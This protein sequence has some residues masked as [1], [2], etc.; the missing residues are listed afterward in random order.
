MFCS[1]WFALTSAPSRFTKTIYLVIAG[2]TVLTSR[3]L[4]IW[5]Y[6]TSPTDT[7]NV[8]FEVRS[9]GVLQTL[10]AGPSTMG[11][12]PNSRTTMR[13]FERCQTAGHQGMLGVHNLHDPTF[14]N[15]TSG[16][17]FPHFLPQLKLG[18]LH[19]YLAR[20]GTIIC[21]KNQK[22]HPSEAIRHGFL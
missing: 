3:T 15:R 10:Q 21:Q 18:Q 8:G 13:R 16:S 7:R 12:V 17:S 20:E 5:I 19:V 6:E 1:Q 14:Q 11:I 2:D 9:T 22:H 4:A